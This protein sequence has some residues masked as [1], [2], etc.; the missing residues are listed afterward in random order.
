ISAT[1]I[2]F[3]STRVMATG[4]HMGQ[5]V[6]MAAKIAKQ[7]NLLPRDIV[8]KDYIVQ[9][10]N[11]LLKKGQFIPGLRLKDEKDLV[12]SASIKASS[13][14]VLSEIPKSE[15][16]RP[17][18]TGT[19]QMIPLKKGGI[20]TFEIFVQS[21]KVTELD[22]ELR[23]SSRQGNHTPDIT[24]EK[25]RIVI[26]PGKES[27]EINFES[28]LEEDTYVFL[29]LNKNPVLNLAYSKRRITGILSVFNHINEA[30]SN[31]GRQTPPEALGVDEFEF[32]CPQRRPEGQNIAMNI[33]HGLASFSADNLK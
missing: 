25:Q 17:L 32:W 16:T 23:I 22:I 31:F 3:A 10:Q 18:S 26:E 11:D 4:A 13:E 27:I 8:E 30:V 21:E 2:A 5:A 19:A 7:H 14:L 28:I 29:I 20:P 15:L 6:G 12:Q 33:K 1:H 24:L 9:L